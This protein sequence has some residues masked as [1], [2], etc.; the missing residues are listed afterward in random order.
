MATV[1]STCA[2]C[3]DS[4]LPWLVVVTLPASLDINNDLPFVMPT[5]YHRSHSHYIHQ[6]P[7]WTPGDCF[8][9]KMTA[10]ALL[11]FN[12]L[13]IYVATGWLLI[14]SLCFYVVLRIYVVDIIV[15]F[16]CL[17]YST[18]MMTQGF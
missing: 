17:M 18:K 4:G 12:L 6:E 5:A 1:Y 9:L 16:L 13:R 3:D 2:S 10:S 11:A 7:R 14:S 15:V 8:P